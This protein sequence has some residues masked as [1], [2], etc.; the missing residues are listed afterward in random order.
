[1]P[2]PHKA[3]ME[4]QQFTCIM[5]F[6]KHKASMPVMFR[7][8]LCINA[9]AASVNKERKK[10][11]CRLNLPANAFQSLP[12]SPS[13]AAMQSQFALLVTIWSSFVVVVRSRQVEVYIG[14]MSAVI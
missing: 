2:H 12:G 13:G 8:N 10:Q 14:F 11:M 9:L 7:S 4:K 5:T 3:A 1:M 6:R